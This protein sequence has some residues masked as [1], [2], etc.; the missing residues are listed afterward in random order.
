MRN[1]LFE[2]SDIVQQTN[3]EKTGDIDFEKLL[4]Q[5]ILNRITGS[6]FGFSDG[7]PL[8]R[9][10]IYACFGACFSCRKERIRKDKVS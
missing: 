5:I 2:L 6:C 7:H 10:D 4:G 1:I 3:I 9:R 8:C